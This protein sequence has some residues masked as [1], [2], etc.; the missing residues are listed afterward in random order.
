MEDPLDIERNEA[1]TENR[2]DAAPA[3]RLVR[4]NWRAKALA[5][6]TTSELVELIVAN[7]AFKAEL[8]HKELAESRLIGHSRAPTIE[9][10]RALQI[11]WR[12]ALRLACAFEL[13]RR[14]ADTA[15]LI[16]APVRTPRDAFELVHGALSGRERETVVALYLDG[17]H[18][19][20]QL[21]EVSVGTATA[22][23]IHPREVFG[24]AL[25]SGACAVVVAHN[26]PSGD[27][28]PSA[29]DRGVTER[30]FAA[31]ELVG[32]PLLDHL[33]VGGANFVSLRGRGAW[34]AQPDR[35]PRA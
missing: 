4:L 35:S 15:R 30:L 11:P 9:L 29:E 18:R 23:L 12:A 21:H 17:R 6:F 7:P 20:L 5:Q 10:S 19:L 28:E 8:R 16:R 1:G 33:V 25:R 3:R 26:H 2:G 27:P 32:V 24:P 13:G 14:S 34:I 31:G 22:S